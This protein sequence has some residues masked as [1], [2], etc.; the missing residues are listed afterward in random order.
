MIKKI[1]LIVLIL[2]AG[3]ANAEAQ[4]KKAWHKPF[5]DAEPYHF[6][7][8]FSLGRMGFV[9]NHSDEFN[10]LDTVYSVE[11]S[12]GALFGASM[13]ANAKLTE[14]LDLRII[15]GLLFGQRTLKYLQL[16]D[17][18]SKVLRVHNMNIETTLLQFPTLVKYRAIR[19]SNYRPYVTLGINPVVDLAARK[20]IKAEDRPKIRLNKFDLYIEAS[21]GL[22]NYL[23]YFKYSTELKFSY[24]LMNVAK[25]DNTEYTK[26]FSRLGSKMVTLL[27]HFE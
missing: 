4:K 5:Y 19:E 8:S 14:S 22:D 6:G 18:A 25:N 15:P 3:F 26:A 17:A 27:I 20:K 13:V 10:R 23:K 21:V 2:L 16:D 11:Y 9:I 1:T 24:G 7:F 12:G